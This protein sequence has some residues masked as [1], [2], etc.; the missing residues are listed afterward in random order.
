MKDLAVAGARIT[1]ID[2][3]NLWSAGFGKLEDPNLKNS[4]SF[5]KQNYYSHNY[6][7]SHRR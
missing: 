2:K 5:Y 1:V 4:I 6:F 7:I 3:G